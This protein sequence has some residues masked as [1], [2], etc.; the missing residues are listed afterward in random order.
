MLHLA[1]LLCGHI[2]DKRSS[3][4]YKMSVVQVWVNYQTKK[5]Y[6]VAII[7]KYKKYI[8]IIF[9]CYIYSELLNTTEIIVQNSV[10]SM[11]NE[12]FGSQID[13]WLE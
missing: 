7:L 10:R 13:G 4:E 11:R 5:L 8:L 6:I 12:E 1:Y 3:E 2:L 9:Y